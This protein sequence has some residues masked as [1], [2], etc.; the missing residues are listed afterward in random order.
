MR[1]CARVCVF[2]SICRICVKTMI[3]KTFGNLDVVE[4]VVC[5]H[6]WEVKTLGIWTLLK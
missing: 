1:R 6:G 4:V 3:V 2:M 5:V